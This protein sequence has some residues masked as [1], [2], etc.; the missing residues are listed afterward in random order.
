MHDL[1]IRRESIGV[2]LILLAL[3]AVPW[4]VPF[5]AGLAD[6]R[7][8]FVETFGLL[9]F[10]WI[11]L[12]LYAGWLVIR[13]EQ[14]TLWRDWK[15]WA[16]GL[17]SALFLVGFFGFFRPDW[18]LGEYRSPST[19]PAAT[20]DTSLP[21]TRSASSPGWSSPSRAFALAW[22][23]GAATIVQQHAV[24]RADRVALA[25]P[26]A[27]GHAA[28][29]GFEFIFPT[30]PAPQGSVKVPLDSVMWA[31]TRA[32]RSPS[33]MRTSTSEP[34]PEPVQAQLFPERS[35]RR[36]RQRRRHRRCARQ[37]TLARRLAA[38]RR[39]T[40]SSDKAPPRPAPPT[41]SCAPS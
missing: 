34:Q 4:L 10:A 3:L 1:L 13:D 8:S 22:P 23:E 36:R 6:A 17:V 9:I 18:N 24:R 35:G 28:K 21:A 16:I 41:T 29:R 5:T 33:S 7:N 25:H 2:A 11:G 26:A 19:R 15:P 38:A 20:S 27:L 30:R 12:L 37:P 14:D 31:Q 39:W 40:C 32:R